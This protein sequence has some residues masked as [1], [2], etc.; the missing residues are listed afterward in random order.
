MMVQNGSCDNEVR[1]RPHRWSAQFLEPSGHITDKLG[2]RL[3]EVTDAPLEVTDY[4]G[5]RLEE[6]SEGVRSSAPAPRRLAPPWPPLA[7][8]GPTLA[9]PPEK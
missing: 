9:P 2:N 6:S 5:N 4:L 3:E 7:P 1:A 8:S